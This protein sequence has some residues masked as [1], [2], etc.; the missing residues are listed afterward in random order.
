[1]RRNITILNILLAFVLIYAP[2]AAAQQSASSG[3]WSYVQA[4]PQGAELIIKLKDGQTVR[5]KLTSVTDTAL[6]ITGK[7]KTET[8]DRNN[9][10]TV[11]QLRRKSE[12]TKY[13][14]IGAGVGAAVGGGIGAAKN[15]PPIDDGELYVM[16]GIPLGAGIG[17]LAGMLFGQAR[18]KRV[19]IYQAR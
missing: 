10:S 1:M 7:N 13:A 6:S 16:V 2:V 12:K 8:L 4:V 3:E 5:G 9:I 19:L 18:R 11:Y 14:L 15:S 17:A